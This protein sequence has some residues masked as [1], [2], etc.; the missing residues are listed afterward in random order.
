[1]SENTVT[2]EEA[3]QISKQFHTQGEFEQAKQVYQQILVVVPQHFHALH[4]LGILFAQ[5]QQA[6]SAI[7]LL[8]QAL[9]IDNSPYVHNDLGKIYG[10]SNRLPQAIA[11]YQQAIELAPDFVQA[12]IN[13]G[14]T[15]SQQKRY[16]E[17]I[18]VYQQGLQVNPTTAVLF[19]Q[20]GDTFETQH[21]FAATI[22]SYQQ[23]INL[24]SQ[25][26][27]T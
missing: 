10:D 11:R 16:L 20:L 24:D 2:L 13:L 3:F 4:A 17:A 18:Q 19:L 12:Y 27:S 14:L 5:T 22:E 6:D 1:M 21:Q 25:Y 8:T 9:Q 7:Q 15:L 26:T 23:A